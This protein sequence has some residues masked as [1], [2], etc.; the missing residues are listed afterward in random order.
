MEPRIRLR[1]F[2]ALEAELREGT[3]IRID[4]RKAQALLAYLVRQRRPQG[5]EHI[6]VLFWSNLT[7]TRARRN[8]SRELS[9]LN[10]CLPDCFQCDYHALAWAAG[11]DVWVDASVLE[12]LAADPAVLAERG[13]RSGQTDADRRQPRPQELAAPLAARLAE[14]V[15]LYRGEFLAGFYVDDCP[16]FETWLL[17]ERE[18]WR[19]RITAIFEL[20]I[21]HHTLRQEYPQAIGFARRWLALEPW[22]EDPHR[23]LIHLL[24]QSGRRAEA[25]TQYELCRRTL[26]NELGVAPSEHITALYQQICS[27][28]RHQPPAPPSEPAPAAPSP[29]PLRAQPGQPDH[30]WDDAPE[31]QRLYGRQ[32]EI[33]TLQRWILDERRRVVGLFGMGGVGK[34]L[35]ASH[36]AGEA[37]HTF[38]CVIWRSLR[39]APPFDWLLRSCASSCMALPVSDLPARS[40]E[41][42]A[43]LFQLLRQRRCL[44]VLDHYEGVFQARAGVGRYLPGYEVYGEL[45]RRAVETPHQSCVL[46]TSR[47]QPRE[48]PPQADA[49]RAPAVSLRLAGLAPAVAQE[50]LEAQGGA[51]MAPGAARLASTY[52]GNPLLLQ[53]VAETVRELFGGDCVAFLRA[54]TLLLE[55]IRDLL[56]Q[57]WRRLCDL[58]QDIVLWLAIAHEPVPMHTLRRSL[59]GGMED[60]R[61]LDALRSLIRRSLVEQRDQYFSVPNIVREY[62]CDHFVSALFAEIVSGTGHRLNTHALR[63]ADAR[64]P[65]R[66]LQEQRIVRPL[67]EGLLARLGREDVLLRLHSLYCAPALGGPPAQGYAGENLLSLLDHLGHD[68]RSWPSHP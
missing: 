64:A 51:G 59:V 20:L 8:L 39:S 52:S 63:V 60:R 5:R 30:D 45:L 1:L 19:L 36:V 25:L 44:L 66:A 38:A 27:D 15:E 10:T 62:A 28:T 46:L 41:Q 22:H 31:V 2:G 35:L 37:A 42:L 6:A 23:H 7:G 54:N 68:V 49:G 57:Q 50:L 14:A 21:A 16:E 48:L 53:C 33:R 26:A 43:L 3:A 9:L 67:M 24:A 18:Q 12:R 56:D 55:E 58:E 29:P 17:L 32:A 65:G 4:S 47:E 11:A 13:A 34:T 40:D 61:V